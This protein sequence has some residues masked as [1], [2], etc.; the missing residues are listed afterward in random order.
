V[1]IFLIEVKSC[2]AISAWWSW[3]CGKS[4]YSAYIILS[5]IT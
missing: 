3:A 2:L 5:F 1:K 4:F